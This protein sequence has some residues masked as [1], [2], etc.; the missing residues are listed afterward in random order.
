MCVT[1]SLGMLRLG[2]PS[3]MYEPKIAGGWL[4]MG[5]GCAMGGIWN[6]MGS[7]ALG[8]VIC[9]SIRSVCNQES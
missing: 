2:M 5:G 9:C 8:E 4:V 1:K 6:P 3:P 7:M